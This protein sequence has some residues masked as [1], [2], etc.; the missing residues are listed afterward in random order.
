MTILEAL[1]D[2]GKNCAS[3]D[4]A[5]RELRLKARVLIMVSEIDGQVDGLL[6]YV[7]PMKRQLEV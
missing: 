1:P 7:R 3:T 4:A 5:R 6:V 2:W